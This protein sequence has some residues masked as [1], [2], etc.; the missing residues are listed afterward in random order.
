MQRA[1]DLHMRLMP[2]HDDLFC[3]S[4]PAPV[5]FAASLMGKCRNELRLPMTPVSKANE[6]VVKRAMETA[7]LL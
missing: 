5:K 7:R 4:N 6:A 1:R 2:L 3:D